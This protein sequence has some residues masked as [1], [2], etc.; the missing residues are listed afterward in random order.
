MTCG[1]H[2]T[3]SPLQSIYMLRFIPGAY[4]PPKSNLL[5]LFR[6]VGKE[7]HDRLSLDM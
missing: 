7:D 6:V 1:G 3:F 2:V 5:E 4:L